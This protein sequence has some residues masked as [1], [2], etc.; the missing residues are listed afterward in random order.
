MGWY[1][2]RKLGIKIIAYSRGYTAENRKVAFYEWLERRVLRKVDGIISVS[3]GQCQKLENFGIRKDKHW[4][5]HN[6]VS[7]EGEPLVDSSFEQAFRKQY[8]IQDDAIIGVA[9]GR[10]S[11]EKG[12]RYFVEAMPLILKKNSQFIAVIC[13]DGPLMDTLKSLSQQLNV[14]QNIRFVGFRRDVNK[15]FSFMDL[16]VLP[17]LTEGLPNVV[18]ESFA[19][20]KPVAVTAVGGVP[21]L[22]TDKVN[23]FIVPAANPEA[24]ADGINKLVSDVN[25]RVLQGLEGFKTV[26]NLFTFDQQNKKLEKIYMEFGHGKQA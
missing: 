2:A 1:L 13:G 20:K 21:E 19:V 3:Q 25:L 4:V 7:V 14:S 9:A 22:V 11:P 12:H 26:K 18:L 23:G 10:L 24:L 15:I 17:S 5:V 16:M 6:A 8:D